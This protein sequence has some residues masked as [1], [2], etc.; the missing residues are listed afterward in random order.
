MQAD[1]IVPEPGNPMSLN[2]YIYAEGNP[3]KYTDPSGH[4]ACADIDC[5]IGTTSGGQVI[6]STVATPIHLLILQFAQGNDSAIN[7]LGM[8]LN[9]TAD[10]GG[11]FRTHFKTG[12]IGSVKGDAGFQVQLRDNSYYEEVW[13]AGE[14]AHTTQIGH[15]LTAVSFAF[16]ADA[17]RIRRLQN[18]I[19]DEAWVSAAIGHERL[20]DDAPLAQ[21]RQPR[22]VGAGNTQKFLIAVKLDEGGFDPARDAL[23]VDILDTANLG[24]INSNRVGNSLEDLRLTARGWS[25]GKAVSSGQLNSNTGIAYWLMENIL[26]H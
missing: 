12:T 20:S 18:I 26:A 6:V 14:G 7:R 22:Y 4:V 10:K 21:A 17:S 2:R 23:L 11:I 16:D 25:L 3:V 5:T 15:F 8:I 13:G 19:P 1:T 24:P 9:N